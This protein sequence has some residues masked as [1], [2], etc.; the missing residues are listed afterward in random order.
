MRI[1]YIKVETAR[2]IEGCKTGDRQAQKVLYENYADRMLGICRRYLTNIQEA[3]D[4]LMRGFVKVFKQLDKLQD[5]KK[6][7]YWMRRIMVNEC[8]MILR[9]N[10]KMPLTE[11]S[12]HVVEPLANHVLDDLA[13][14]DILQLVD[15]LPIGYKTVFNMYV[16]EGFKHKEIATYLNISI[17]T[18]KSQLIMARRKLQE[19]I[20][21]LNKINSI[22]KASNE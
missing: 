16:V 21:E 13:A 18:S 19:R 17:N 8:L 3:E 20:I 1:K 2:L 9:K 5:D 22:K 10:K 12:D 7:E 4:A 15:E 6:L 11:L 14:I